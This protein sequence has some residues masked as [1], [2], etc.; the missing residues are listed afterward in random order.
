MQSCVTTVIGNSVI[1]DYVDYVLHL[2]NNDRLIKSK[3]NYFRKIKFYYVIFDKLNSIIIQWWRECYELIW[4]VGKIL[5]V[6]KI[7]VS[8]RNQ[9]MCKPVY[10]RN[11]M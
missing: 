6:G 5:R 2:E 10:T 11:S 4:R 9:Q 7:F 1:K 8:P 3:C